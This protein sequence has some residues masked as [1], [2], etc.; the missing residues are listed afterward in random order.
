MYIDSG[1]RAVCSHRET[2]RERW[3][4]LATDADSLF[5]EVGKGLQLFRK[6]EHLCEALVRLHDEVR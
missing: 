2:E 6:A 3:I 4:D 5:F 1:G